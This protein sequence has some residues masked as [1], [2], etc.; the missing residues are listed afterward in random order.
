MHNLNKNK[1]RVDRLRALSVKT[2][3][4]PFSAQF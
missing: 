3:R 2:L 4:F 1:E